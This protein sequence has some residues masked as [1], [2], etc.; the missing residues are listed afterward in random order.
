MCMAAPIMYEFKSGPLSSHGRVLRMADSWPKHWRVLEIGTTSGYIGQALRAKGFTDIV[1]CEQDAQ[2]AEAARPHYTTHHALDIEQDDQ[3]DLLG[4]CD[5]L[6]CA[7]VLEHVRDPLRCLQQL[8]HLVRPEGRII[9]SL[10]NAVNWTVRMMILAGSFHY[11]DRGILD[12]THLQFF[13][14][15]TACRLLEDAGLH[16][17]HIYATPLPVRYVCR[18]R[19][20]QLLAAALEY[21]YYGLTWCRATLFAYQFVFDCR[22]YSHMSTPGTEPHQ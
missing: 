3:L 7:D 5:A 21:S 6:I 16:I 14:R 12:R 4:P 9:V 22:R 13:T 11:A 20:P 1:G 2:L 19:L 17:A 18:K 8:S 10:P 15:K